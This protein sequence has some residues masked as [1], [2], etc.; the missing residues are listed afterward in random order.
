VFPKWPTV[1]QVGDT[2]ELHVPLDE[3]NFEYV[4]ARVARSLY[5]KTRNLDGIAAVESVMAE[6]HVN[7]IAGL[8]PRQEQ[9]PGFLGEPGG[10]RGFNPDLDWSGDL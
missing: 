10:Q 1:P 8:R 3:S 7:F 6:G 5:H 2:Y 4:S 9:Q